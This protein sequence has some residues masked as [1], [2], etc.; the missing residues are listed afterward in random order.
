MKFLSRFRKNRA[1][2]PDKINEYDSGR[3][4]RLGVA[5]LLGAGTLVATVLI[6]MALFYGVRF[7]YRQIAGNNDT[8][9]T[10]QDQNGGKQSPTTQEDSKGETKR[11]NGPSGRGTAPQTGD[12]LPANG[13]RL[14]A[15]GDPSL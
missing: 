5:W 12:R 8:P 15:T 1:I 2:D 3:K 14:P 9:Q 10:T 6:T 7:A 4:R 11:S 13:D